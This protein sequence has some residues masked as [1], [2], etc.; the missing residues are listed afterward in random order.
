MGEVWVSVAFFGS[1]LIAVGGFFFIL[2]TMFWRPG[3]A[4]STNCL[5]AWSAIRFVQ[6]SP[7]IFHEGCVKDIRLSAAMLAQNEGRQL[8][9]RPSLYSA[10][11][12]HVQSLSKRCRSFG[13]SWGLHLAAAYTEAQS[14]IYTLLVYSDTSLSRTHI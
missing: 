1:F 10:L 8:C 7:C 9:W 3:E 14:C 12:I 6:H 5:L 2:I 11:N 4:Y 13:A